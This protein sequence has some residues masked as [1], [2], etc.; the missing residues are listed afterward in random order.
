MALVVLLP[1]P[2]RLA[3][4]TPARAVPQ[5][6]GWCLEP[7]IDGWRV[8]VHTAAG[9]VQSRNGNDLAHR[10]PE[11]VAAGH[12]LGDV[13][14]D[15]EMVALRD[16]R[17]DFTALALF[18]PARASVGVVIYYACFDLL[19]TDT[20]DR[21]REPYRT[22]R[23]RLA[24]LLAGAGPLLQQVPMTTDRQVAARWLDPAM[25]E[26]GIEGCVAKP[27]DAPYRAG[28]AS[29]W[30]KIRQKVLMDCLVVGITGP[31]QRPESLVLAHPKPANRPRLIGVTLPLPRPVAEQ[32]GVLLT[33]LDEP[34]Q[35]LPG[36]LLGLPGHP[37]SDYQPVQPALIVE[38]EADPLIEYGRL[39]HRVR[40]HRVR[41]EPS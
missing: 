35:P 39:R 9:I 6:P 41:S 33:P 38:V 3:L 19:A 32:L 17:L 37:A 13:V 25:A 30:L 16:G 20:T 29:G 27:A 12:V 7:K 15:G 36:V 14:I 24:D 31:A 28:R 10:F 23:A 2:V 1:V 4:A 26:V 21:R 8:C 22:R 5:G 18:P 34:R 11:I 40:L